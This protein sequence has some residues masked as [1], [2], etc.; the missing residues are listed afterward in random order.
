[1][2]SSNLH[3]D[4]RVLTCLIQSLIATQLALSIIHSF[5]WFNAALIWFLTAST[6]NWLIQKLFLIIAISAQQEISS[7][8]EK[9]SG[10]QRDLS[11]YESQLDQLRRTGSSKAEAGR[12]SE[13]ALHQTIAKLKEDLHATKWG[14]EGHH[15]FITRGN[16][17]HTL[18]IVNHHSFN[19]V[20]ENNSIFCF[21]FHNECVIY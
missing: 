15:Q 21:V 5:Y 8:E 2:D 14:C 16:Q 9:V 12:A 4:V 7:L 20:V 19:E 1:M 18:S 3:S 11:S 6:F 10:L 17:N 13:A